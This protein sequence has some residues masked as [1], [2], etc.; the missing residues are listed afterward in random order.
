MGT[1][2]S[3]RSVGLS[4]FSTL[5]LQQQQQQ[6]QALP[7]EVIFSPSGGDDD[8]HPAWLFVLLC[9]ISFFLLEWSGNGFLTG[10]GAITRE[11]FYAPLSMFEAT[12]GESAGL[13]LSS[14]EAVGAESA[15]NPA[16][17][18]QRAIFNPW[19]DFPPSQSAPTFWFIWSTQMRE[20][21]WMP[22]AVVESVFRHH[23]YAR[24]R[25]LSMIMP[26]DFFS[27]F[28]Q[29]G[30]DISVE[31]YDL[32]ELARGTVLEHFVASGR[33]NESL[34][35]RYAHE[36]D[37]LRL[38]ILS[39]HGGIY[40]DT[41]LL[42]LRPLDDAI[43]DNPVLGVEYFKDTTQGSKTFGGMRLNNAFMGFPSPGNPYL[44]WIMQRVEESYNPKEWAAIGPDIITE[45]Y[46]KQ[47]SE[48]QDAFE[49][50]PPRGLYPLHWALAHCLLNPD[51]KQC[52]REW[53][54]EI[55][56]ESYGIH[57][58]NSNSW[59]YEGGSCV[60]VPYPLLLSFLSP[61]PHTHTP[62]V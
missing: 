41:D 59:R 24:V 19:A 34:H 5:L 36:S 50:V 52:D 12:S 7:G 23:P 39:R 55:R 6:Q 53:P 32:A 8:P 44:D 18:E 56:N 14:G 43:V 11:V 4:Q 15:L 28:S 61:P 38:V 49:L 33:L 13:P 17:A 29:A 62:L 26:L 60:N 40:L 51:R 21:H 1:P 31:R 57:L 37:L 46:N 30:Y 27:C 58:Y 25:F 48:V 47:P 54:P 42:L 35:F 22:L 10:R 45:G 3:G 9:V 2:R 16:L 20:W